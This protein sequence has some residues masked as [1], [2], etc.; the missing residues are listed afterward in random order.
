MAYPYNIEEF[1]PYLRPLSSMT[2]EERIEFSNYCC[3]ENTPLPTDS[4]WVEF[5]KINECLNW[6]NKHHFNYRLPEYLYIK[7]TEENNPYNKEA[8]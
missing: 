4:S 5:H 3:I 6:L 7:V 8:H 1:K 2:D